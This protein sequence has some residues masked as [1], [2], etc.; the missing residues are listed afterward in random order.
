LYCNDNDTQNPDLVFG[1]VD[2][3]TFGFDDIEAA[4]PSTDAD[5][6]GGESAT[7]KPPRPNETV[8]KALSNQEIAWP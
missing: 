3:D 1:E 5:V 8:S 2:I 6:P 7:V 4:P